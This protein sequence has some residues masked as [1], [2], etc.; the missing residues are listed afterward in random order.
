MIENQRRIQAEKEKFAKVLENKP[1]LNFGEPTDEYSP[2]NG[3][4]RSRLGN[5]IT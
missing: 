3:R 2:E 5:V 4:M 1:M